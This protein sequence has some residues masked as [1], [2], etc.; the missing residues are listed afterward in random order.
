[1]TGNI[2]AEGIGTRLHPVIHV[3]FE[4]FDWTLNTMC[5]R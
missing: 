2:L 5:A 3:V 4:K 1:M